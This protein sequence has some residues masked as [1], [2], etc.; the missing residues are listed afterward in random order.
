M[1][2]VGAGN[3]ISGEA[4]VAEGLTPVLGTDLEDVAREAALRDRPGLYGEYLTLDLLALT[5]AQRAPSAR[6][7]RQRAGLRGARRRGRLPGAAGGVPG[8]RAAA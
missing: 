3:G 5:D 4:L 7:A 1:L 2:D 6:A 8:G